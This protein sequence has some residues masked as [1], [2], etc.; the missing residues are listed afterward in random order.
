LEKIGIYDYYFCGINYNVR[1][2][3]DKQKPIDYIKQFLKPDF[4]N[5]NLYDA[6]QHTAI[7]K[8]DKYF[9]NQQIG[10]YKEY[11]NK[12]GSIPALFDLA[13]NNI[14]SEGISL[15]IDINNRYQY[16]QKSKSLPTSNLSND[17]K[18]ILDLMDE[19]LKKWKEQ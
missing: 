12:T 19:S 7:I 18:Y 15:V 5:D 3:I 13:D 9:I 4:I 1:L 8:D 17:V 6:A 14:V 16:I 11:R 10:T 2:D